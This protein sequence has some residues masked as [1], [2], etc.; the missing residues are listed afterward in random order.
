MPRTPS[1]S[2]AAVALS[3]CAVSAHAT[4]A[5]TA[6]LTDFHISLTDLDPSDGITPTLTLDPLARS[7]VVAGTG[8]IPWVPSTS[9]MQQGDSAFGPVSSSGEIDGTGGAGAFAGDPFGAGAQVTASATGGPSLDIGSGMAFIDGGPSGLREFVL[10][11]QTQVTFSAF[12]TLDWSAGNPGGAAYDEVDLDLDDGIGGHLSMQYLTGGY[13]GDGNGDLAGS[14]SGELWATLSN[15][16]NVSVV[17]SYY[18]GVFAS[19]SDL[20]TLP[21][22]IDEP[23]SAAL[24]L[25]G[26][27]AV[28]W[29]GRR[30]RPAP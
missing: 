26:L 2:L 9:W 7:T 8:T 5:A 19:A 28:P 15:D 1:T 17:V 20:E 3:L 6:A 30:R 10:S 27:A 29:I 23:A 14:T 11:A 22:P 24:L 25:A 12:A 21:P 16:S 18:V 13:Y 4:S